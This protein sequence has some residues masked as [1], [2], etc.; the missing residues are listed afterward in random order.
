MANP[1]WISVRNNAGYSP[2]QVL[3]KNGR[4]DERIVTTFSRIGGPEIFSVSDATG[5][6]PIH[7]AMRE[8]I[9]LDTLKCLIR[10][11]PDALHLKTI[12][13]DSPLHLACFRR[14][15]ADVVREI[16][17]ASSNG[18]ASRV[19]ETNTSG[20]T[21]IGIA[22]E[23]FRSVCRGAGMCWGVS[24]FR[25]EQTRAFQVL[26]CL[27]KILYYG[28]TNPDD[29][30]NQSLIRACVS[31]HRQDVRLDPSFIRHA[32]HLYPEEARI[33]DDEG[34]FPLHI[35]ASIPVEKMSLLDATCIGCCGGKCHT[36][37]GILRILLEMYP[38]A[39]RFRNTSGEF[40]LGLMIQNGRLWGHTVALAFLAF[41]PALHWYKGLDDRLLPLILEKASKECGNDTLFALINSR[42]DI[43]ASAGATETAN[44]DCDFQSTCTR[45]PLSGS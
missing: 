32:T 11:L 8:D 4:I 40:P 2:L 43:L 22:M 31:L 17:I 41:P 1:E 45:M 24:D 34:N 5:N 27:V 39:T 16:A 28:P 7:S 10:A 26:A 38:E 36:R 30:N 25:P 18:Q 9:N 12:Y 44:D 20:Q 29:S 42:P 33:M 3:C 21:P 37:M 6:T 15:S 14:A 19:L 35:E 23:E 13:G